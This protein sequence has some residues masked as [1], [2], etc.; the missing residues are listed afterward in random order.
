MRSR[1]IC[2]LL[3]ENRLALAREHAP[4]SILVSNFSE[5]VVVLEEK[6]KPLIRDVDVQIGAILAVLLNS[7]A[8]TAKR[9]LV[10]LLLILASVGYVDRRVGVARAHLAL[11]ALQRRKKL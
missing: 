11:R 4:T 7:I 2:E 9:I 8:A 10:D 1:H 5:G 3:D 6:S